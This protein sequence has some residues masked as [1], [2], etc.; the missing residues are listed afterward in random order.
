MPRTDKVIYQERNTAELYSRFRPTY[1]D[2]LF[3][4]LA[5]LTPQQLV[6]VDCGT[7]NGQ[8]AHTLGRFFGQVVALDTSQEQLAEAKSVENVNYLACEADDIP[9]PDQSVDW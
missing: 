9:L 1:P 2:E 3:R 4:Y 7:G 6:A 8:A 5:G